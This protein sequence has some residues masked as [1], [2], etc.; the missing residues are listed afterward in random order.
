MNDTKMHVDILF[1]KEGHE[2]DVD[3]YI[4]DGFL[5]IPD[6]EGCKETW[7]NLN[8]VDCLCGVSF[9]KKEGDA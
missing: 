9:S 6:A 8:A 1:L 3:C 4:K 5:I 2:R 7:Y